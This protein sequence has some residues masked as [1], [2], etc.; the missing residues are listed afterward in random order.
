MFSETGYLNR[1]HLYRS[2]VIRYYRKNTGFDTSMTEFGSN[3]SY[4]LLWPPFMTLVK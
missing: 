2:L 1:K 4:Q 3:G